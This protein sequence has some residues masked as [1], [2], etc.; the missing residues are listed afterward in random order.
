[1]PIQ[2][3]EESELEVFCEFV[4][5]S[6]LPVRRGTLMHRDP[7]EPDITCEIEGEGLVGFE[8]TELIDHKF[9]ARLDLMANTQ[10]ALVDFWQ[11]ALPLA[12]SAEFR[13]MYGHAL[14]HFR[15]GSN[16]GHNE[17]RAA[18][19]RIFEAML[20]LPDDFT[21]DALRLDTRFLPVLEVVYIR[22]GSFVGPAL[23]VDNFGW[24]GDPTQ[25]TILNKLSKTYACDYPI[26][27]LAYVD[28]DILPPEGAWK[29]AAEEAAEALRASQLRRIWVFDRTKKQVL[30]VNP[31]A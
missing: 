12:Q 25:T 4:A 9:L 13:R 17:R 10:K 21:G 28:W 5:S 20:A 2:T 29:A 8:I 19:A 22:R 1:M 23:D 24:I 15:F 14:L 16:V 31:E 11:T 18:F 7:P 30:Y 6:G 3:Q 26:D 27:L